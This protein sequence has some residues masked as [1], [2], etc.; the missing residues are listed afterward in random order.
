MA[1]RIPYTASDED[2]YSQLMAQ[3]AQA[4]PY[5]AAAPVDY[6]SGLLGGYDTSM[7]TP[8]AAATAAAPTYRLPAGY[9]GEPG[10]VTAGSP[11]DGSVPFDTMTP[12]EQAA[13]YAQNPTMAAI[14]QGLQ[15]LFGY[16]T[17]GALQNAMV[18]DFVSQQ[19]AIANPGPGGYLASMDYALAGMSPPVVPQNMGGTGI[20][21]GL[22]D[23]SGQQAPAPVTD[24]ST[25]SN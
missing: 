16:T 21:G 25:L 9:S 5:Y 23:F 3:F 24:L 11:G 4:Q 13:Y 22:L 19:Q 2:I 17:L 1:T 7:Y 15:G 6:A 12:L 14:T 10:P 18:P 8:T 20:T